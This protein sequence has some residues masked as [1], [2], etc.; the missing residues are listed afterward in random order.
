M[1]AIILALALLAPTAASADTCTQ[2]AQ[3]AERLME[4]R[5]ENVPIVDILAMVSDPEAIRDLVVLAYKEPLEKSEYR[6][7]QAAIN[8]GNQFFILC[9][10]LEEEKV[11]GISL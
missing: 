8:F 9:V 3:I 4:L 10:E 11:E 5:Q 1:K 7:R 6:K 2:I